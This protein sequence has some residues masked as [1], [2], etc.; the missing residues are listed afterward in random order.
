MLSS[1][2]LLHK[3]MRQTSINR[4]IDRMNGKDGGTWSQQ[5]WEVKVREIKAEGG[6]MVFI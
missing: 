6:E 4:V 3:H 5:A 1:L 2:K